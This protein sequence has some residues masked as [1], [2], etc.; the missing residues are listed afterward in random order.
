MRVYKYAFLLSALL[1]IGSFAP[2]AA[3]NF[4]VS[5]T[6]NSDGTSTCLG[7]QG[8][9]TL[10][11]VGSL[12]RTTTCS[13]PSGLQFTCV[14]GQAGV[15]S[16][17]GAVNQRREDGAAR[18]VVT[19]DGNLSCNEEDDLPPPLLNAPRLSPRLSPD[20][21]PTLTPVLPDLLDWP[22]VFN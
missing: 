11:C 19:G 14:V 16:C 7:W 20:V 4:D 12:G 5:C 21:F 6:N 13:S 17:S 3:R 9:Q 15:A 2:L 18:C 1:G 22:S 8:G 10:T